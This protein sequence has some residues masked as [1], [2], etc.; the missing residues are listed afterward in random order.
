MEKPDGYIL[1]IKNICIPL[2][3]FKCISIIFYIYVCGY[4]NDIFK[5]L[6]RRTIFIEEIFT[7]V[8]TLLNSSCRNN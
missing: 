1:T 4:E 2:I 5:F 6:A 3:K 8:D 7:S